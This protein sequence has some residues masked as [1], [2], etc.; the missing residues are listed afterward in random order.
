MNL[1]FQ[2]PENSP[3]FCLL[4]GVEHFAMY[5]EPGNDTQHWFFDH[6]AEWPA[7]VRADAA[8]VAAWKERQ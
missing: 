5:T 1:P 7:H 2:I 4:N 3:W 8:A 6:Y